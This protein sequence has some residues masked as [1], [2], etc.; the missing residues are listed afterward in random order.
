MVDIG[1]RLGC[2]ALQLSFGNP[3]GTVLTVDI[4]PSA[5]K[6]VEALNVPNIVAVTGDSEGVFE[7]VKVLAKEIDLLYIDGDHRLE[8]VMLDYTLY[9]SIVRRGGII[10]FDDLNYDDDMREFWKRVTLPKIVLGHLH[11]G[12]HFG[13]AIK[14]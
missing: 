9:G 2:S 14:V 10:L 3:S 7:S 11:T 1:T 13:L 5:A 12:Y 8:K 6:R 4:D